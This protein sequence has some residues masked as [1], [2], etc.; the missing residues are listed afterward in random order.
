MTRVNIEFA[1][2][3]HGPLIMLFFELDKVP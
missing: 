3:S 2:T 1:I